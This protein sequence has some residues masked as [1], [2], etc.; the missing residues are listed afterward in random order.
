MQGEPRRGVPPESGKPFPF[1]PEPLVEVRRVSE[2][3]AFEQLTVGVAELVKSLLEV[4]LLEAHDVHIDLRSKVDDVRAF[5][6][7]LGGAK[8]KPP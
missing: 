4:K 5:N 7:T 2:V 3:E 8:A 1:D 6:E